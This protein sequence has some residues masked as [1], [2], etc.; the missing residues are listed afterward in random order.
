M[1]RTI[2]ILLLFIAFGCIGGNKAS[3]YEFKYPSA[4]EYDKTSQ[5][6]PFNIDSVETYS[7]LL[8]VIDSITCMKKNIVLVIENERFNSNLIPRHVCSDHMIHSLQKLRNYLIITPDSISVDRFHQYGIKDLKNIM[9]KHYLNANQEYIY[10]E[11][12]SNAWVKIYAKPESKIERTKELILEIY[13]IYNDLNNSKNDSMTLK[14]I[15]ER[16]YYNHIPPP[17]PSNRE[18]QIKN[19]LQQHLL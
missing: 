16:T 17:P 5:I 19:A 2:Y 3:K 10:P 14:V 13:S 6:E 15:F 4:K 12:F 9:H 1:K 7:E 11:H 18:V 8:D